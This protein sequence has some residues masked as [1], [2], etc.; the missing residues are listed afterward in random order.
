VD[1]TWSTTGIAYN[2]QEAKQRL[3]GAPIDSWNV[4]FRP[5]LIR[6]FADCGV[7]MPDD[8]QQV[9][10][11]ALIYLGA[12]PNAKNGVDLRRAAGVVERVK[13][14]V[15]RFASSDAAGALANGDICLAIA[16][17]SEAL[18]AR[19]RARDSS[20][21]VEVDYAIPKEGAP[22]SLDALAIPADAPDPREARQFINFLLRPEIAARDSDA[23]RFANAVPAAK[24]L[25]DKTIADNQAIYPDDSVMDRLFAVTPYP[26]ALQRFAA[27]LWSFVKTGR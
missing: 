21:N 26:P 2:V 22:I 7:S 10:A 18:Q 1:Y 3:G 5:D 6:R 9:F 11:S 4:I 8:P 15:K 25:I 12:N 27:R 16:I 14:Y 17:S 24:P 19:A 20:N 13:R 23:T